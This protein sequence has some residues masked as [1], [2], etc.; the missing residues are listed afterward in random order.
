MLRMWFQEILQGVKTM[1]NPRNDT[2][3]ESKER[4]FDWETEQRFVNPWSQ[5][6]G[7]SIAEARTRFA[8]EDAERPN[9]WPKISEADF[10]AMCERFFA[11]KTA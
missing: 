1:M 7:E 6:I 2:E 5:K 10:K 4:S 9:R 11:R 8:K 3:A